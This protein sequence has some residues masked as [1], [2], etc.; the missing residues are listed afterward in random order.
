MINNTV[1][2][3]SYTI[4]NNNFL[5]IRNVFLQENLFTFVWIRSLF[6]HLLQRAHQTSWYKIWFGYT[7]NVNKQTDT[8]NSKRAFLEVS[9]WFFYICVLKTSACRI[10]LCKIS[11]QYSGKLSFLILMS[12]WKSQKVHFSK[13]KIILI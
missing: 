2:Y 9:L 5:K 3:K 6:Y 4:L 11:L 1:I 10:D 7:T 8:I 13:T 12:Y